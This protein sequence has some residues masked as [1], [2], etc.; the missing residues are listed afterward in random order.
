MMKDILVFVDFNS[1]CNFFKFIPVLQMLIT[2]LILQNEL[3]A[4]TLH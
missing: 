2:F 4:D 1:F 3:K